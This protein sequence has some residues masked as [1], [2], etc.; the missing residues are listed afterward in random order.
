MRIRR[1]AI[2]C[3]G[4]SLLAACAESVSPTRVPANA[5]STIATTYD[6]ADDWNYPNDNYF[7]C[8]DLKNATAPMRHEDFSLVSA[9]GGYLV[10]DSLTYDGPYDIETGYCNPGQVRLD[11]KELLQTA[12]GRV[13]LHKG[14][15]GYGQNRVPYGHLWISDIQSGT[16]PS[17]LVPSSNPPEYGAPSAI[18]GTNSWDWTKRNGRGCAATGDYDYYMHV[19]QQGGTDEIP[20][21]WQYKPN[22]TTSRYNKY[23]DA[24]AEQAEGTEHYAYL[25]WSWL[26]KGD[27]VTTS[28]GGGMVR[29]L[30]KEGQVFHRCGVNSINSVAYA[31]GTSTEVGRVTAIYGKTRASADG[32]WVYGWTIHS[33]QAKLAG[34]GYGPRVFHVISCPAAGC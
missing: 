28:P 31:A 15:G 17:P 22:Q 34:G 5:V 2:M 24:G 1:L 32:P 27:G 8:V 4:V 20:S 3:L 33:H 12:G 26:T 10:T 19:T 14:G 7:A 11:A 23:A 18:P 30:I 13:Y 16:A 21:T 25:L 29:A 6:S 9:S